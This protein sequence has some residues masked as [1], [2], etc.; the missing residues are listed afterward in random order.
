MD[1]SPKPLLEVS[2]FESLRSFGPLL[3]EASKREKMDGRMDGCG[4]KNGGPYLLDNGFL[5]RLGDDLAR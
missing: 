3:P 2:R 1:F 5:T 4:W